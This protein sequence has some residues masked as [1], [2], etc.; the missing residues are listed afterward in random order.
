ME[1]MTPG[2]VSKL[3]ISINTFSIKQIHLNTLGSTGASGIWSRER[4]RAAPAGCFMG[5]VGLGSVLGV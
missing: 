1:F 2:F 5:Q 4:P 3:E